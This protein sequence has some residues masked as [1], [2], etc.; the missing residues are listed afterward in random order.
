ML[1]P[2]AWI[3]GA[4]ATALLIAPFC[5]DAMIGVIAL[6]AIAIGTVLL[7]IPS[8]RKRRAMW[9]VLFCVGAALFLYQLH[10]H[11]VIVPQQQAVNTEVG[12][13]AT[14]CDLPTRYD[15]S[16]CYTLRI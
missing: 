13:R 9:A 8:L 14:V 16:V 4:V 3:G 10:E 12:V 1:R 2:F 11:L 15:G 7:C 5:S 6:A